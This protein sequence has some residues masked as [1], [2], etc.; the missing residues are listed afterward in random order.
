MSESG[1]ASEKKQVVATNQAPA[2]LGPYSQAVRIGDTLWC[3]GQIGL[4]PRSGEL[5]AGG[6][7]AQ[8]GQVLANLAAVLVAG[9]MGFEDVVKTT[10][11][12][13]DLGD[14]PRVNEL[15]AERFHEPFP[16]RA[17]V[18]V[19]ALPKGALIEIDLVAVA[20]AVAGGT[21]DNS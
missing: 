19:A 12:L 4:D 15:Y 21:G 7:D 3:S 1:L 18:G 5:V 9:K 14:F 13:V 8:A 20:V 11:Y 10:I 6:F 16:A 2:A 17:T